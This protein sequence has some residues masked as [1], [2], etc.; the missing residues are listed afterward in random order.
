MIRSVTSIP[1]RVYLAL[2]TLAGITLL[3]LA[4]CIVWELAK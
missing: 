3:S 2:G 4:A 1:A